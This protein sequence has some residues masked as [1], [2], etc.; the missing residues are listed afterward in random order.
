MQNARFTE[1]QIVEILKAVEGGRAV[2]N[3]CREHGVS[4]VT[5]VQVEVKVRRQGRPGYPAHKRA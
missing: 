2:T 3:I 5:F 4:C 1:S